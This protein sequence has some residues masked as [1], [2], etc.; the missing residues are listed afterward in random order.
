[1]W[2]Y[3]RR[4]PTLGTVITLL[5]ISTS[6]C[7]AST[8]SESALRTFSANGPHAAFDHFLDLLEDKRCRNEPA[9]WVNLAQLYK[10]RVTDPANSCRA[11]RAYAEGLKSTRLQEAYVRVAKKGQL[12]TKGDCHRFREQLALAGDEFSSLLNNAS[13][14]VKQGT[15]YEALREYEF[16]MQLAPDD[17]RPIRGLCKTARLASATAKLANCETRLK[18]FESRMLIQGNES[19]GVGIAAWALSGVA[20]LFTGLTV[21]SGVERLSA[22]NRAIDAHHETELA[23]ALDDRARFDAAQ[24]DEAKAGVEM[25]SAQKSMFLYGGFAGI[26]AL[27]AFTLWNFVDKP[28]VL[29]S[30]IGQLRFYA[31]F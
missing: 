7:V 14:L 19:D 22:Y 17:I 23:L 6:L 10:R 25:N 31:T 13:T 20:V 2:S 28:V 9:F 29:L 18:A 3:W 24:L 8:C 12:L 11:Y 30:P 27:S 4:V 5:L 21:W 15:L 26:S 1:M 16:L